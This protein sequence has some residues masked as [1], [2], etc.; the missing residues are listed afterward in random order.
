MCLSL[1]KKQLHSKKV[2]CYYTIVIKI[3][4]KKINIFLFA[5]LFFLIGCSSVPS[6]SSSNASAPDNSVKNSSFSFNVP[7]KVVKSVEKSIDDWKFRGFGNELPDWVVYCLVPGVDGAELKKNLKEH[8][9]I[10]DEYELE[11]FCCEGVNADHAQAATTEAF[12]QKFA[13]NYSSVILVDDFWVR[14]KIEN[15]NNKVYYISIQIYKI[16]K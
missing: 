5:I 14:S 7:A 1:L 15:E 3:M 12:N 13:G 11:V 16:K 9:G 6:S 2:T 8:F 4:S 10:G